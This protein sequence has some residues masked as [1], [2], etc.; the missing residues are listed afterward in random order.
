MDDDYYRTRP[1]RTDPQVVP[2]YNWPCRYVNAKGQFSLHG[3][4]LS[5]PPARAAPDAFNP[6]RPKDR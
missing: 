5:R 6:S 1:A 2:K 3:K 4:N